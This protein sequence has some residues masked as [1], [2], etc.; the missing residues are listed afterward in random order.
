MVNAVA[1]PTNRAIVAPAARTHAEKIKPAYRGGGKN[2]KG[3]CGAEME[4]G[5]I[6]HSGW[7][8]LKERDYR[9]DGFPRT[10]EI[11]LATE[12]GDGVQSTQK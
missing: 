6:E 7:A 5:A 11:W 10:K 2:S 8:C 4:S 12:R 9:I 3:N 1:K